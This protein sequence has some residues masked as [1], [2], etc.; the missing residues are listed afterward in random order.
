[1]ENNN[2]NDNVSKLNLDDKYK[3]SAKQKETSLSVD[4]KNILKEDKKDSDS[5]DSENDRDSS[6][7]SQM[8]RRPSSPPSLSSSF[9]ILPPIKKENEVSI[10]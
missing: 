8:K 6:E 5:I 2:T 10:I 7:E 1:M 4:K 3:D 9:N